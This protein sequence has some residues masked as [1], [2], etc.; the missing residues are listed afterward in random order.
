MS[1]GGHRSHLEIRRDPAMGQ[2]SSRIEF[3]GL[4]NTGDLP[5]LGYRTELGL[6]EVAWKEID[7]VGPHANGRFPVKLRYDRIEVYKPRPEERLGQCLHLAIRAEVKL[8]LV[9]EHTQ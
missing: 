6:R 7:C 9:V 1:A 4:V 3:K 2:V 8:D 5:T